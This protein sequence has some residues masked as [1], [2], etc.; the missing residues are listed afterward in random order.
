MEIEDIL[1]CPNLTKIIKDEKVIKR[2]CINNEIR[3]VVTKYICC[4]EYYY[5]ECYKLYL[6]QRKCSYYGEN[7]K[8][9][10]WYRNKK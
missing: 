9:L 4:P 7:K 6:S 8:F 3:R 5:C 1:E 10:M 2:R